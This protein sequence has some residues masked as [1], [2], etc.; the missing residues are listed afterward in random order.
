NP[1]N[2]CT[3]CT[4]HSAKCTRLLLQTDVPDSATRLLYQMHYHNT[5]ST[6][7]SVADKRTRILLCLRCPMRD[8]MLCRARCSVEP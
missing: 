6:N 2:R 8:Q 1:P 5:R 3:R 7:Q 4:A